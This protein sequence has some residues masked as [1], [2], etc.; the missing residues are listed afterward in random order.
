MVARSIGVCGATQ[1]ANTADRMRTSAVM[2]ATMVIR[3]RRKL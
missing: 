1:G 3:E 2:A